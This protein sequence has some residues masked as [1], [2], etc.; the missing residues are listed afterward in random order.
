[1]LALAGG[2]GQGVRGS[3]QDHAEIL[4][5]HD[6]TLATLREGLVRIEEK[7]DLLLRD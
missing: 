1:V 2:F 6:I 4:R 5:E 7:L 3:L